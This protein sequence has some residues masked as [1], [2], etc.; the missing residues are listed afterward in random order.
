MVYES[1]FK[2]KGNHVWSYFVN[3]IYII[4]ASVGAGVVTS[5]LSLPFDNMKTKLQ[6][7]KKDSTGKYPYSGVV[8]CFIKSV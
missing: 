4:S 8:D 6:K 5:F 7:M 2:K 3:F 1:I